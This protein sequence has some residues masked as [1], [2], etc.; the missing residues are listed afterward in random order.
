MACVG[1]NAEMNAGQMST[2]ITIPFH[3]YG[4]SRNHARFMVKNLSEYLFYR[5]KKE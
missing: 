3:G 5:M 2:D 4:N 1:K